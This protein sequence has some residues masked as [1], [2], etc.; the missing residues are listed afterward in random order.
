MKHD[1]ETAGGAAKTWA[2]FEVEYMV[3]QYA[4]LIRLLMEAESG[5]AIKP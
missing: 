2:E 1:G 4:T 5:A 3:Y